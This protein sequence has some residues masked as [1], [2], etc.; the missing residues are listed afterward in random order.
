M[1]DPAVNLVDKELTNIAFQYL[2]ERELQETGEAIAANWTWVRD[3][4]PPGWRRPARRCGRP[5]QHER[6]LR[7]AGAI[8]ML[9][10]G[11]GLYPTRSHLGRQQRGPSACS[12]VAAALKQMHEQLDE[13][14]VEGIWYRHR[15]SP[16]ISH[17]TVDDYIRNRYRLSSLKIR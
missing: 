10:E 15:R 12:I 2:C 13:R 1:R 11:V 6:H 7:I 3:P 8:A 17:P 5:Q 16:R 9:V 14:T 4:R